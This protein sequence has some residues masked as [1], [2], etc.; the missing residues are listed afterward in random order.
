MLE[1]GVFYFNL[2]SLVGNLINKKDKRNYKGKKVILC[3]QGLTMQVLDTTGTMFVIIK[4]VRT[5]V[6]TFRK[7]HGPFM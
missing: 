5:K 3:A 7:P 6:V 4:F 1:W 2:F